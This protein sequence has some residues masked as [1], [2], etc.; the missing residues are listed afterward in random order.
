[1]TDTRSGRDWTMLALVVLVG[2][3]L[4]P[5]LAARGPLLT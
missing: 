4:R 3:N 2:L 1:M 5:F